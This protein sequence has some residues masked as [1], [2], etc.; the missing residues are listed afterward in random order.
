MIPQ[1]FKD[2]AYVGIQL[3]LFLV[4]IFWDR[5]LFSFT[6]P[7]ILMYVCW[8]ILLFSAGLF[9]FAIWNIRRALSPY[10]SPKAYAKLQTKGAF[11]FSRHPIYSSIFIGLSALGILQE[12]INQ[13]IVAVVLLLFFYIKASYEERLL[14]DMFPEYPDYQ[15][16]TGMI[17]P[18]F[19]TFLS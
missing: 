4:Y 3:V 17:F 9:L 12:N 6:T 1:N 11:A 14:T 8:L 7:E 13:L 2:A 19:F 5:P 15:K 10:P 16:K 18:K